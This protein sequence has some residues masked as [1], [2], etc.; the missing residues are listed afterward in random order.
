M[1]RDRATMITPPFNHPGYQPSPLKMRWCSKGIPSL[2]VN[3][4]EVDLKDAALVTLGS[5]LARH[6]GSSSRM[7]EHFANAFVGLG[8]ALEV[9]VCTN[10]LA[11]LLTLF[12]AAVSHHASP[13]TRQGL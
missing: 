3:A 1:Y 9:L 5:L 11:D 8:R 2:T 12:K 13:H 10:L 7:L 6:Q 4:F